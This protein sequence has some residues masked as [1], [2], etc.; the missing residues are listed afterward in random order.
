MNTS[1]ERS[2][3][4]A[5]EMKR[6]A[7]KPE[8]EVFSPTNIVRDVASLIAADFDEERRNGAKSHAVRNGELSARSATPATHRSRWEPGNSSPLRH[9]GTQR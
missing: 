4:L 2:Q 8:W 1:P 3:F 7:I 6:R 5:A 9:V